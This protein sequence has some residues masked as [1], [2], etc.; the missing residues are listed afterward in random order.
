L[1]TIAPDLLDELA[2]RQTSL[3]SATVTAGLSFATSAFFSSILTD[4]PEIRVSPEGFRLSLMTFYE[5]TKINRVVQLGDTFE[6][7]HQ[8]SPS[9]PVVHVRLSDSEARAKFSDLLNQHRIP[10]SRD[11]GNL[12]TMQLAVL[13]TAVILF[14]GGVVLYR[15]TNWDMRWVYGG[16][17]ALSMGLTFFFERFRGIPK[18]TSIK[19]KVNYDELSDR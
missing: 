14:V 10:T 16:M 17:V 2:V 12:A 9:V 19:A 4:R 15:S 3:G 7:Y 8:A 11:R 5:W 1:S 13:A 18:I 6:I